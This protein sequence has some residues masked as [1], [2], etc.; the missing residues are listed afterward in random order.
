[1]VAD[2][3]REPRS[4]RVGRGDHG[5][6]TRL[7]RD[8]RIDRR[9]G[10]PGPGSRSSRVGRAVGVGMAGAVEQALI[11]PSSD[12]GNGMRILVVHAWLK[13]NLGDVLQLS[14]LL[15]ALRELKPRVLDLAGFPAR[16]AEE[17]AEVLGAHRPL[18][19]RPVR[20]VLEA[21]ADDRW[22]TWL[23]EP[24]VEKAAQGALLALRRDRLCARAIPCGLRS[25]AP[26]ARCATSP[27]RPSSACRSCSRATRS[28]R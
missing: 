19:A 26:R 14:V 15:S 25:P 21:R 3:S 27:S 7:R 16:P 6:G 8:D 28:A 18:S 10:V 17:T 12:R 1:M 24:L 13:G 22:R 9:S 5:E 11:A 23:F 20:L 2:H 4:Q